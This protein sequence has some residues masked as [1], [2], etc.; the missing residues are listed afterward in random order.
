MVCAEQRV[1]VFTYQPVNNASLN[2]KK[3]WETE[4]KFD[5]FKWKEHHTTNLVERSWSNLADEKP[6]HGRVVL[7]GPN[8]AGKQPFKHTNDEISL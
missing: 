4:S 1:S 2:L 7:G 6:R 5:N 3:D 8:L